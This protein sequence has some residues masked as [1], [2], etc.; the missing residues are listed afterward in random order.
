MVSETP[1]GAKEVSEV[2][3]YGAVKIYDARMK[4]HLEFD[5]NG[6]LEKCVRDKSVLHVG[7][8]DWPITEQRLED[9]TLLHLRLQ[10]A[11]KD[12]IGIDLSEV[13]IAVLKRHGVNNVKVMNA[14]TMDLAKSFDMILAGDV[15]EHM[16]NPGSFLQ[17]AASL[18]RSDGEMIIGVPS[19]LTINNIKAWFGGWEQVHSDHTFY[20][21]PKTLSALLGR[22]DLLP[23]KLVFTVQPPTTH[24]SRAFLMIRKILLKLV[25]TMS[26]S[27][28]MHFKKAE[29]V[30]KSQYIEWK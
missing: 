27:I 16:N 21:S 5:R 2:S 13:G 24:E 18:L 14:E 4:F 12:L 20:F 25:K 19:A 8:S 30:D 7:C 3:I 6:Y 1:A 15:L 26:P 29:G 17:R 9:G 28:I 11:A 23:V 22:F 10:R